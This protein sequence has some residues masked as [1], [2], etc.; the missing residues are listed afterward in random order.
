MELGVNIDHIATLRNARGG[1]FPSPLHAAFV[2]LEAGASN[3]TCHLRED[4]RHIK[5]ED[6]KLISKLTRRLNFE[7]AAQ[8]EI[9]NI[10]M[11]ILPRSITIVPERRRELTT[12]GGLNVNSDIKRYKKIN[13]EFRSK[14]ISVSAFIE[15]DEKQIE[16]AKKAEFDFIELHTGKYAEFINKKNRSAELLK[17]EK[18][19]RYALDLGL[20]VN[21]GHGL[22]YENTYD[23]ASIDGIYE[24]NI[25]YSIVAH[26]I[27]AGLETAVKEMLKII[28]LKL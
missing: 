27:F 7:M 5:D 28:K 13:K 18:A 9:I 23:I 14:G 15:P 16:A 20:G 11:E 17:I 25:G 4:R 22:N 21:A 1:E 12:E 10:A 8:D 3:V 26:S 6:V 24:L 19:V 2:V